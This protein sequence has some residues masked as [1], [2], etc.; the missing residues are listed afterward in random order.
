MCDGGRARLLQLLQ[1]AL[2]HQQLALR[3]LRHGEHVAVERLCQRRAGHQLLSH[4]GC[5]E[6]VCSLL[7]ESER[8]VEP[9]EMVAMGRWGD[10]AMELYFLP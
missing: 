3:Q 2:R 6:Q 10:G 1:L 8:A 7:R 5:R 9:G 4:V